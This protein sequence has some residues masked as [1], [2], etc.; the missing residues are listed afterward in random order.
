MTA[1]LAI[2]AAIWAGVKTVFAP[3]SGPLTQAV[4]LKV[5]AVALIAFG[6]FFAGCRCA[7]KPAE[8]RSDVVPDEWC[9]LDPQ[10]DEVPVVLSPTRD[11]PPKRCPVAGDQC[12]CGCL[13]G[14]QCTCTAKKADELTPLTPAELQK[15]QY[16]IV[17]AWAK[18]HPGEVVRVYVNTDPPP[19]DLGDP[20]ARCRYDAGWPAIKTPTLIQ[21]GYQNGAFV[22]FGR[23]PLDA[24]GQI[25]PAA[26]PVRPLAF[27]PPFSGG[28][29]S[30]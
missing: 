14:G 24:N 3:L 9:V 26:P 1:A 7:A 30:C 28:G 18:G 5:W 21:G 10:R 15:V 29:R 4:S 19:A 8:P 16:R 11:D 17:S 6:S 2:L 13:T 22:E 27:A 23:F 25:I 12:T 20:P